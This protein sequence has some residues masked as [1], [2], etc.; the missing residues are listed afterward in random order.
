MRKLGLLI[1]FNLMVFSLLAQDLNSKLD[2]AKVAYNG[3]NME[4]ARFALEQSLAELDKIVGAEILKLLPGELNGISY[5]ET[6]DNVA[7]AA[8]MGGIFVERDYPGESSSV[9]IQVITDSPFLAIVNTALTNPL[10]ATMSGGNQKVIKLDGYKTL[11]EN[12]EGEEE[13]YMFQV[14]V[15]NSL[16]TIETFGIS[17][18]DAMT[19]ASSLDIRSMASLIGVGQ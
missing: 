11:F 4:E 17:E 8:G 12:K 7:G 14:P 19:I 3:G 6:S 2:E 5:D 16:I 13:N 10:I 18:R 1:I 9:N 15:S